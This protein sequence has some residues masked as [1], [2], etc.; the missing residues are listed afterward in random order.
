MGQQSGEHGEGQ[1]EGQERS[2][3]GASGGVKQ[4]REG[5]AQR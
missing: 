2:E 4:V 1:G 5:M 3:P